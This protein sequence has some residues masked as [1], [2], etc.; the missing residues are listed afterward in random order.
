MRIKNSIIS[1]GKRLVC[2]IYDAGP[3]VFDR[4]AVAFKGYRLI[5][6]GM[7]YP[8]L[9]SSDNPLDPMG[10]GQHGESR[11]YLKGRGLGKRVDFDSLPNQVQQFITSNI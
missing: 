2:R 1:R 3:D 7:V 11:I 8:Y 10:F 5:H 4:Y 9:A 6:Y